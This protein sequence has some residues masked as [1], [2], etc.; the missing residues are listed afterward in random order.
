MRIVKAARRR[1]TADALTNPA[2]G[3]GSGLIKNARA[4]RYPNFTH[5]TREERVL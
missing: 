3:L 5:T 4:G 1:A 2:L